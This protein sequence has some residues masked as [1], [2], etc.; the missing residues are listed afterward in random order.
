MRVFIAFIVV[1]V[2][3]GY[4]AKSTILPASS[5]TSLLTTTAPAATTMSPHEIHLNYKAM[6]EL[7][8]HDSKTPIKERATSGEATGRPLAER[9]RVGRLILA[10]PATDAA[11][12]L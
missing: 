5:V 6:K 3:V 4:L 2:A 9:L 7:P 11:P 12:L 1:A 8:V 10:R